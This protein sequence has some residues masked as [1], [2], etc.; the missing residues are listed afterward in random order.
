LQILPIFVR[1]FRKN[2]GGLFGFEKGGWWHADKLLKDRTEM[3]LIGEAEFYADVDE[4][5]PALTKQM[6]GTL[7]APPEHPLMRGHACA[8]PEEDT[9]VVGTQ[10]DIGGQFAEPYIA[11]Q[12]GV[13]VLNRAA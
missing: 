8:L 3:A 1:K 2:A 12:M 9:E 10:A 4:A 6:F 5:L 7:H 11:A 13:D